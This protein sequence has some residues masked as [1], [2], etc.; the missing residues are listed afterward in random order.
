[1]F[2][3]T[4]LVSIWYVDGLPALGHMP[5]DSGAP[6]HPHLILLLHLLHGATGAHIEQLGDEASEGETESKVE[7][8]KLCCRAKLSTI[9]IG[10]NANLLLLH[11]TK[12]D[13]ICKG[14]TKSYS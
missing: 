12:K 14:K 3:G 1:L 5:G 2:F 9:V 6:G 11:L 10:D 13:K 8:Y 7:N 4:D